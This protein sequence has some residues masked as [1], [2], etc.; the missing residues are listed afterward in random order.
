MESSTWEPADPFH[1]DYSEF[2]VGGTEDNDT[3]LPSAKKEQLLSE[4]ALVL[5]KSVECLQNKKKRLK[6]V[7]DDINEI[8]KD[9]D[10]GFSEFEDAVTRVR[11][12]TSKFAVNEIIDLDASGQ[13]SRNISPLKKCVF[14]NFNRNEMHWPKI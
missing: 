5:K 12:L 8:Q 7:I 4:D 11:A 6:S 3:E 10:T 13:K 2:S 1:V 14:I 9:V